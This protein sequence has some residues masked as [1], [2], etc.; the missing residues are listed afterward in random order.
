MNKVWGHDASRVRQE[1]V[2]GSD[3]NDKSLALGRTT[4]APAVPKDALLLL[5]TLY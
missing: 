2:L 3:D 1:K 4:S 5:V